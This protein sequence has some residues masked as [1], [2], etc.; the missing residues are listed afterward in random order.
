MKSPEVL[1]GQLKAAIKSKKRPELQKAII[2]CEE[3]GYPE[4]SIDLGQAKDTLDG[5]TFDLGG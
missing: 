5:M 3:A 2:E 1:R 4:L